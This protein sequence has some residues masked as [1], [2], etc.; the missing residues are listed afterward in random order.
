[1]IDYICDG[2]KNCED[3]KDE[4]EYENCT[5]VSTVEIRQLVA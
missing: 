5:R 2:V 3:G 1:M 4:L